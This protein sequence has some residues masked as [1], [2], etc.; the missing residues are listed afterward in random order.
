MIFL[1]SPLRVF[2]IL[3]L[4]FIFNKYTS[5][6]KIRIEAT[7][8]WLH[9]LSPSWG[10]SFSALI[11]VLELELELLDSTFL[12]KLELEPQT[13]GVILEPAPN[14]SQLSIS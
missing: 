13:L 8:F 10:W 3:T 11:F 6:I 14:W 5:L 7:A 1:L 9:F 12:T 2:K 4:P